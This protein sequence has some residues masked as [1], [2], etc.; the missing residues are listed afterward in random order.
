M[1]KRNRFNEI[2]IEV[3]KYWQNP[4]F[5]MNNLIIDKIECFRGEKI[6]NTGD[7]LSGQN[8]QN[9]WMVSADR[10]ART[11]FL[12]SRPEKIRIVSE[13]HLW[14]VSCSHIGPANNWKVWWWMKNGRSPNEK[15]LLFTVSYVLFLI[16]IVQVAVYRIWDAKKI[17]FTG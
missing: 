15:R 7:R 2:K 3:L 16:Q 11:E 10:T 8:P 13:T 4:S 6:W 17:N 5:H 1:N 9:L 12:S 14:M